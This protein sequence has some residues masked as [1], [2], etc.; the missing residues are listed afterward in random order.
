VIGNIGSPEH[1]DYSVVGEAV[2][3]AARL[4]GNAEP[5]TTVVSD[6]VYAKAK[7]VTH[8]NFSSGRE[9]SIK[10]FDQPVTIH[11]LSPQKRA[12]K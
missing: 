3:L 5:M 9:I 12:D 1:L 2:N 10:G 11:M 6:T 7:D 8:Y 4:C